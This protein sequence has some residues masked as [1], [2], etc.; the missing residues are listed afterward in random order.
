MP[1]ACP[2][3]RYGDP[4]ADPDPHPRPPARGI[5]HLVDIGLVATSGKPGEHRLPLHPAHVERLPEEVRARLSLEV[6]YGESF[7]FADEQLAPLVAGLR[8]REEFLA[9]AGIV[10]LP[11][12]QH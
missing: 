12:P 8:P 1:V 9:H 10:V 2:R 6:G 3:R 11:K 7:G 4:D 5:T